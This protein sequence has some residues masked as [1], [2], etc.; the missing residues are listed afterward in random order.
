[1]NNAKL[2]EKN[3]KPGGEIIKARIIFITVLAS[4]AFSCSNVTGSD[5][6][7]QSDTEQALEVLEKYQT[8]YANQDMLLLDS[9]HA[10]DFLH[11]LLETDWDDYDGD[12]VID[13]AFNKE[14]ELQ[15][16]EDLF[17]NWDA[18]NLELSGDESY[19]WPDD[20][21]G[22]SIAF[23]RATTLT[24]WNFFPALEEIEYKDLIFV[25]KPDSNDIWQLTNLIEVE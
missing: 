9:I 13:T 11:H 1:M 19:I 2:T 22:K 21:S 10:T 16:T 5:P 25:C 18:F 7:E 15:F 23:P 6:A 20:P 4:L 17:S 24:M 8:A 12:G 14:L 3:Q